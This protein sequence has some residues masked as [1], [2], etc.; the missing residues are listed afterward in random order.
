MNEEDLN[1]SEVQNGG[2]QNE[3]TQNKGTQNKDTHSETQNET[4]DEG[5]DEAGG[6]GTNSQPKKKLFKSP[7][8]KGLM[9]KRRQE[10][11]VN[12]ACEYLKKKFQELEKPTSVPADMNDECY[13]FGQLIAA[14]LR[15]MDYNRRQYAMHDINNAIFQH[16][17]E[18]PSF[19]GMSPRSLSTS[20]SQNYRASSSPYSSFSSP[21]SSQPPSPFSLKTFE[22][23]PTAIQSSSNTPPLNTSSSPTSPLTLDVLG[24]N[25]GLP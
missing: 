17:V 21:Y 11:A 3:G 9:K 12:V 1:D 5:Q 20:P 8:K 7:L 19:P 22:Y 2:T 10:E 15:K 6:D 13:I 14:K 25:S 23:L 24:F 18:N 16:T 4:R